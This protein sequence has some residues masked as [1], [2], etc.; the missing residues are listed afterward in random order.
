MSPIPESRTD[1]PVPRQGFISRRVYP[2]NLF[3][4][5][6]AHE[7]E[8]SVPQRFE[9]QAR[10]YPDR[11]AVKTRAHAW[12]YAE[13]KRHAN[14]LA[15]AILTQRG[16]GAEPI[17]VLIDQGAPAIAAIFGV[18]KAGKFFVPLDPTFPRARLTA[19]LED[20]QTSLLVTDN[21]QA[22]LAAEL[23]HDRCRVLNI[24]TLDVSLSPEN[25]G[26]ACSPD[27]LAYL[28]YTSGSTGQPKGVIQNHR[29]VLHQAMRLANAYHICADDRATLLASLSAAAAMSDLYSILL[30]G[31]A[32]YPVNIKQE[33][34]TSLASWLIAE[35]ITIY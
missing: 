30:N 8:Q 32:L 3:T 19:M 7:V 15:Q 2:T 10:R 9:A 35:E 21:V 1:P 20:A 18:L 11:L 4:P 16:D 14:R 22:V 28:L 17:A 34:L 6:A 27:T 26:V 23:A 25:P 13:L 33:G 29:N 24:E 5:I 12:T 31:A